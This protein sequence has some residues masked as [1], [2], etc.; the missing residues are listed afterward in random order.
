MGI[1]AG[2]FCNFL[3]DSMVGEIDLKILFKIF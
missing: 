2:G 3:G 1:F